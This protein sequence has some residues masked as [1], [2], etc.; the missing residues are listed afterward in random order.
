SNLHVVNYSG[1]VR[2]RMSLEE[3]R[4]RLHTLP[5]RPDSVPYRTS[6]YE[7]TWGFCMSQHALDALPEGDYEVSIDSTLAPGNLT[8]GELILPGEDPAEVVLSAH[9]CHPSL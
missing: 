5:D 7:E 9:V 8:Y 3:L 2:A 1:P 4:P 6:Y